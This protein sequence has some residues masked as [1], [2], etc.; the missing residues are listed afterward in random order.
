[1]LSNCHHLPGN[2]YR[3]E[4]VSWFR[5][6]SGLTISTLAILAFLTIAPPGLD[7]SE[8][9]A[10]ITRP[11]SSPSQQ[12]NFPDS[13]GER[14]P[15]VSLSK[16]RRGEPGKSEMD[17]NAEQGLGL[18]VGPSPE[19]G[20]S[21]VWV[22]KSDS[23]RSCAVRGSVEQGDEIVE[24]DG[25]PAWQLGVRGVRAL[26]RRAP[27]LE[28]P[29]TV[30]LR[31]QRCGATLPVLLRRHPLPLPEQRQRAAE[32]AEREGAGGGGRGSGSARARRAREL[33]AEATDLS[34]VAAALSVRRRPLPW[35]WL[36]CQG[37]VVYGR[38]RAELCIAVAQ[39]CR[40]VLR[41]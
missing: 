12:Q 13:V 32:A 38:R 36:R 9:G 1:M 23:S 24:V 6:Q 10:G 40:G 18:E 31:V 5:N 35:P 41:P 4:R 15:R 26:L 3:I 22:L 30:A 8:L 11:L 33:L 20:V 25:I 28:E 39:G 21:G 2:S 19:R 17:L 14:P 34:A 27:G 7:S 16:T 37:C 29:A